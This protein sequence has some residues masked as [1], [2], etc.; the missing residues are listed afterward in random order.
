MTEDTRVIDMP[1]PGNRDV[2][3]FP[4]LN[5]IAFSD[6]LTCAGKAA[7]L[8]NLSRQW[9]RSMLRVVGDGETDGGDRQAS[10][11]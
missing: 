8:E 6:A 9:R 3:W 10:V 7:A 11:G 4:D 2:V 5:L 1:L